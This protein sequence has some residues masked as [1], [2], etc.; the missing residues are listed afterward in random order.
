MKALS[1]KRRHPLAAIALLLLGLLVTGGLYAVATT[2]NQAKADTTT[3]SASDAQ[4][5][6]KLFAANCAT[7]HGMGASGTKDAPSLVGVGAA[8]VDFQVGTGRMPMQMNGPQAQEKPRQFNDQQTQQLAAYVASLGAGPAIPDAS[9]LDE[10]GDA[11]KG[12]ELFRVNCAM[13]HNAAAAGG[14]LTRGKFAPALAGVSGQHI[15]EAMATGPQNMP[16]FNDANIS[17][18]GK[19]DIITFL[20]TIEANGSPGGND[21]GSLGPVSEGLFV[22]VAG[23]GVIIAFTIWLTSRTS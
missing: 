9:L 4:E 1:Q 20:K 22:W 7:C 19:R 3:F 23:L 10:K 17:P 15:Y 13:C 18:E 5:G 21:L 12:G 6:G 16:V 14:A 11:A 8:A 2:V